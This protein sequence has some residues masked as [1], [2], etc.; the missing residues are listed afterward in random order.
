MQLTRPSIDWLL[1]NVGPHALAA[2]DLYT[3]GAEV[4][5]DFAQRSGEG[6]P[7]DRVVKHLIVPR[8]GQY[9]F[10][11]IVQHYL[12]QIRFEEDKYAPMIGLPQFGGANVV[13]DP[14]ITGHNGL[15][16]LREYAWWRTGII[17]TAILMVQGHTRRM[18]F[19]TLMVGA[20]ELGI[21]GSRSFDDYKNGLTASLN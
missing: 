18:D 4:L 7:D 3:D 17:P 19:R 21:V 9:V 13:L 11:D 6:S 20:V 16:A 5:W 15:L 10:K 12:Q 1:D 14:S 8:S 2:R